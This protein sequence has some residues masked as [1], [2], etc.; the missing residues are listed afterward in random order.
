MTSL[1][2]QERER[3]RER[4]V[5]SSPPSNSFPHCRRSHSITHICPPFARYPFVST[6]RDEEEAEGEAEGDEGEGEG[7]EEAEEEAWEARRKR[8][9]EEGSLD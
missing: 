2:E 5:A 4:A 8:A 3:E 9:G 7:Q 6:P 1:K